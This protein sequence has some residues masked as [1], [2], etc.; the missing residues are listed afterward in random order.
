MWAQEQSFCLASSS[1]GLNKGVLYL[2]LRLV[3]EV[4][5]EGVSC[6]V[7]LLALS[8]PGLQTSCIFQF[9]WSFFLDVFAVGAGES[10]IC[11]VVSI[12]NV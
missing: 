7:L 8:Y 1:L 5:E 10:H 6:L 9:S 4:V 12:E 3:G 2:G 11:Q